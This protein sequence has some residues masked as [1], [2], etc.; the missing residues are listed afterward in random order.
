MNLQCVTPPTITP[1]T[2]DEAKEHLRVLH[3][4]DDFYI[5]TLVSAMAS[6]A[7][8]ICR[9]AIYTSTWRLVLDRFRAREIFLPR[10]PLQ[11]VTSIAYTDEAGDVITLDTDKYQ[12]DAYSEPARLVPSVYE[13]YW[14][15]TDHDRINSVVVT[16]VAGWTKRNLIPPGLRQAMLYHLAHLYDVREPVVIG[17]IAQ[18]IPMTIDALY[19]PHRVVRFF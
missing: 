4:D 11:S 16:F 12:V 8:D 18:R 2:L 19:S 9:R 6:I 17:T 13:S 7:G 10:P 5:Q 15:T 1:F 3:N 14:P